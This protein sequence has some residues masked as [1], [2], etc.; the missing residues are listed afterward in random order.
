MDN[1]WLTLLLSVVFLTSA[2]EFLV[3]G[4]AGLAQRLGISRFVMGMLLLSLATALPELSIALQ[5]MRSGQEPLALGTV[6]GNNIVNFGLTMGVAAMVAT[7]VTHWRA[8]NGLLLGLV[9]GSIAV[10]AMG[11]DGNISRVEGIILLAIFIAFMGWAVLASRSESADVHREMEVLAGRHN[12]LWLD[13]VFV[14]LGAVMLYFGSLWI[15][16][17]APALGVE[18]GL[19]PHVV[20]LLPIAIA[21]TL[22][23]AIMAI[24]AARR[25]HGDLVVGHVIGSSLLNTTVVIGLLAMSSGGL[26]IPRGFLTFELPMAAIGACLMF[27]MLRGD[28]RITR[29]EGTILVIT[30]IVWLAIELLMVRQ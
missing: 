5:A 27:P 14:A 15:V 8:L 10:I 16:Q 21:V 22:P 26:M 18:L 13:V 19:G 11:W 3:R 9:V 12:A 30:F 20:G 6:V 17:K 28:M 29:A 23:E 2:A 7:L 1:V 24:A 4:S 25:G